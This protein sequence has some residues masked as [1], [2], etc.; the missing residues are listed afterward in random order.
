[1]IRGGQY[2]FFTV[3]AINSAA[4]RSGGSRS[5]MRRWVTGVPTE[6]LTCR[7]SARFRLSGEIK[8]IW[9]VAGYA[10]ATEPTATGTQ[11]V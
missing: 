10:H 4:D 11:L 9:A 8:L 5:A 2:P 6:S 7:A 3:E 1:M